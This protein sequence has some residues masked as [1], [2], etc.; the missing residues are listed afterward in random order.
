MASAKTEAVTT[1]THQL[2]AVCSQPFAPARPVN[3][4]Q[5]QHSL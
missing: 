5:Q 1:L 2:Q 4:T 3:H